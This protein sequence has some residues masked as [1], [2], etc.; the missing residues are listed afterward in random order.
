MLDSFT[1]MINLLFLDAIIFVDSN[2]QVLEPFELHGGV[3]QGS[4]LAPCVLIIVAE[5]L[6]IAK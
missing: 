3:C 1:N 2:S 5:T 4:T 6:I